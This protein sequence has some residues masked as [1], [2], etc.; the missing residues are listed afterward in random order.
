MTSTTRSETIS[1]GASDDAYGIALTPATVLPQWIDYNGHMNVGYYAV[2][3][4]IAMGEFLDKH[5][6]L[7]EEVVHS[8]TIGAFAVQSSYC[9]FSE[10]L[11]AE[12]IEFHARV[13]AHDQ[14]RLHLFV[15]MLRARDRGVTATCEQMILGVDLRTR[16]AH[17]FPS[18]IVEHISRFFIAQP[19]APWPAQAGR[20]VSLIG[21]A[22]S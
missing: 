10:L 1:S 9:Y 14:K 20:G 4:D 8:R 12:D 19:V 17:P 22:R 18:D 11:L 3:F 6:A 16:R 13:L 15:T 7:G 2:A 21:G 5:L